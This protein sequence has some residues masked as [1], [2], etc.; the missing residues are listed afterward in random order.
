MDHTITEHDHNQRVD[1][2]CR[3]YFKSYPEIKLGDIFSRIRKWAIKVNN[4]KTKEHYRLQSGDKITRD[5]SI[6]TEKK[7]SDATE[8]KAKKISK[9]NVS[10]V[11]KMIIYEDTYR[12]V[13]NKPAGIV[14]H[15]WEKHNNDLTM[16]D[17]MQ[18]YL[19]QTDWAQRTGTFSPQFCFRLDKDTSWILIAAKTYDALQQ[20]NKLIKTRKVAKI[21]QTILTWTIKQTTLT[22]NQPLYTWFDKKF[23]KWKTFVNHE[24]WKEAVSI[25]NL[26]ESLEHAILWTINLCTVT[27]KT[28]R[29]H[30]IRVHAQY[31]WHPVLGDTMYGNPAL[32]R[33]ASKKYWITRQLLHSQ[34]YWFFDTLNNKH[35][36]FTA[37][38]PD[39]FLSLM[40]QW[41]NV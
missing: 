8:T 30:Q 21:Y 22:I 5:E 2:F 10:S 35:M 34:S 3:K 32:N 20:L 40:Q 24:L 9:I 13:F 36:H 11:K 26:D 29:M 16:H 31:I 33:I 37:P 38:T 23:G 15:P 17:I 18:A 12:L 6:T 4:K 19:K 27:I 39:I 1:R 41:N 14:M 25:F 7:A 28:W